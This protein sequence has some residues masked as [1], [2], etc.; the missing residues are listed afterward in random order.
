MLC[1]WV[2]EQCMHIFAAAVKDM[3]E[4]E[5]FWM[6]RPFCLWWIL[7]WPRGR[8]NERVMNHNIYLHICAWL[9]FRCLQMFWWKFLDDT[10]LS[11]PS[12]ACMWLWLVPR[13][14]DVR[15]ANTF[16]KNWKTQDKLEEALP[17][18]RY[19]SGFLFFGS[20]RRLHHFFPSMIYE[21]V[22]TKCVECVSAER[23][24]ANGIMLPGDVA[25]AW[26]LG[27]VCFS[28]RKTHG[29]RHEH[30]HTTKKEGLQQCAQSE[31]ILKGVWHNS[32]WKGFRISSLS[33]IE[34]P[35]QP[36]EYF[37]QT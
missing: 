3:I 15:L 17:V 34:R 20:A 32:C 11:G 9:R 21:A 37:C 28:V 14:K 27:K 6:V 4:A 1:L 30:T 29:H 22:I 25:S 36:P 33:P 31:V 8:E 24:W 13:L 7:K 18:T 16:N 10:L 23:L 35:F 19:L 12:S 26:S 5:S 2:P